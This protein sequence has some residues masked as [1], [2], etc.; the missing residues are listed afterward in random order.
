MSKGLSH[1][2]EGLK[3]ISNNQ[4]FKSESS[5]MSNPNNSKQ[6]VQYEQFRFIPVM[7]G[8]SPAIKALMITS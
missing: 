5:K 7:T 4:G 8:C 2:N 6:F 1:A 3:L